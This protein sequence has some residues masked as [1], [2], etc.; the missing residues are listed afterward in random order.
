MEEKIKQIYIDLIGNYNAEYGI[1]LKE[2]PLSDGYRK[3]QY[4]LSFLENTIIRL[5][6][7]FPTI[8]HCDYDWKYGWKDENFNK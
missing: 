3:R 5:E 8:C 4:A 7:D 6:S 2:V 1:L